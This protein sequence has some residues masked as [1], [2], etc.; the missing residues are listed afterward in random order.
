MVLPGQAI[1]HQAAERRSIRSS[2]LLKAMA[3]V[4]L[5]LE[6]AR[7][8][9]IAVHAAAGLAAAA[10]SRSVVRAL[11]AAEGLTRFAIA[12]LGA[13]ASQPPVPKEVTPASGPA[14]R[15]RRRAR[16]KRS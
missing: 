7:A 8:A 6:A 15:R 13:A 4:K 16:G 3:S 1:S 2:S 10:Q 5:Q 14:Q 11:R 9:A 12:F